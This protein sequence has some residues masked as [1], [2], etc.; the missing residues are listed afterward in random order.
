MK[1]TC[2]MVLMMFM[3]VI[4]VLP[5]TI[6]TQ[7]IPI[8]AKTTTISRNLTIPATITAT[9]LNVRTLANVK[10]AQLKVNGKNVQLNRNKKVT[11]LRETITDGSKWYY[12]SFQ[13]GKSTLKGFVLS[14][15]VKLDTKNKVLAR[16][17]NTAG[18]KIQT[19]AGN[20]K[21]YLKV[22]KKDVKIKHNLHL[23]IVGESTVSGIKWFKVEFTY[24]KN[25]RTGY[26]KASDTIFREITNK[27]VE[28][29]TP[30]K[31]TPQTEPPTTSRAGVITGN[32]LRV[33][34]GAG[35]N[36]AQVFDAKN[37]LIY[38]HS[39]HKV[40]ILSESLQGTTI[41][42]E[43]GFQYGTEALTGFVSGDYVK[44]D[45]TVT[46][47]PA[48]TDNNQSGSGENNAGDTEPVIPDIPLTDAEFET[49][50]T[51][52]GF[53]E[54]YK[55][56][57]RQLHSMYPHWKFQAYHTNLDWNTAILNQS[58]VG[59]N[60]ITNSK[61]IGWKSLET[62][63]YN[64]RTDTFIPYDGSTWVTASKEAIAYYMD[65]RNFLSGSGIFQFELL[66]YQPAYQTKAG[67][68]NILKNT[69]LYNKG[70]EYEDGIIKQKITTT[71]GDTFIKAAEISLVSPYHLASRV[72]QEVVTGTST[73][74]SSVSGTVSGY[75]GFY[76][77]FN[78]GATHST[79]AG[80]AVINGLKY[81]MNGTANAATNELYMIP[82]NSPYRS[83]VGGSNFIG[84]S[85]INRGQNTVYLQKF[86]ST[87][88]STYSHQYMANVEAAKT[89]AIK[90][91]DAYS[92][93]TDIPIVFSIPIYLNMPS[94]PC[95]E[96]ANVLNPNNLLAF[97]GIDGYVLT[98]TFNVADMENITYN[99]IVPG[100][101]AG[102][103]VQANPVNKKA[104]VTGNGYV[105]LNVGNNLVHVA[106]TAENGDIREY[107]INIVR[108][109]LIQ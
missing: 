23:S 33:R 96:P 39:G 98:P 76:N 30:Q 36:W 20:N 24:A 17:Y 70:Y 57:L 78:I 45:E 75:E 87:S 68:E 62:G 12:V 48:E 108:D 28:K 32:N 53:P 5:A 74:S 107:R 73:L 6:M 1:K 55:P 16:V 25:T 100:N 81:A 13:S 7:S 83:I 93:M 67:V 15:Y 71:Y 18:V 89:E 46:T 90:T 95:P 4:L 54:S 97:L 105:P 82:W 41:W 59:K 31:E 52:Q 63:A 72:K 109:V 103:N 65:P 92:G 35:T 11:I 91:F 50:L 99:L 43:V 8:Q 10:S 21:S 51:E 44:I 77:F 14:D 22:N 61:N 66:S 29:E 88:I 106:V 40:T 86:N 104:K 34:A 38:L 85:Y 3:C 9:S 47:P 64:W 49:S 42:Y 80:G 37:N 56:Y 102:V 19:K 69:A 58:K 26:M 27:N 94:N 60:L 2:H 101:I 84:S 79:A